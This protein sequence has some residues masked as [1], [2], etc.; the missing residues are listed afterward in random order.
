MEPVRKAEHILWAPTFIC[1]S[2]FAPTFIW[3]FYLVLL[4]FGLFLLLLL[5]GPLFCSYFFFAFSSHF[6][7]LPFIW[8]YWEEE[9]HLEV[10]MEPIRKAEHRPVAFNSHF[11]LH[12]FVFA[13]IFICSH[14]LLLFLLPFNLLPFS[15][16]LPE[17]MRK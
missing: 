2:F 14:F 9:G 6:Y 12:P 10:E 3:S 8:H 17:P 13:P 11:Y 16:S 5:F 1:S 4:L 7:F 15:S